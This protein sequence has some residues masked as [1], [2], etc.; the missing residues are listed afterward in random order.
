VLAYLVFLILQPFLVPLAWAIVV[1]VV[2]YEAYEKLARRIGSRPAALVG[3]VAIAVILVAPTMLLMSGFVRQG[4][5]AVKAT[6]VG[7]A[8]GHFDWVNRV[9]EQ[10]QERI[11]GA[12]PQDLATTVNHYGEVV[13]AFVAARLGS[14]LKN[15][16]EF[17]FHLGVMLL[18]VFYLFIDGK[19]IVERLEEVLPFEGAHRERMI[20]EARELIF[21]SVTSSLAAAA[22]H[23]ILGGIAFALTGIKAPIFW[24]VMM[25]FFSFVPVVGS[26]TIWGPAAVSLMVSGHL[27]KGIAL[28]VICAVIVGMVDNVM[29]PWLIRG[30]A[31]MGGLVIFISVLGGITVFGLLGIV[32]GPI[33]VAM[34]ASL[35][36]V[37]APGTPAG[38]MASTDANGP[39]GNARAKASGKKKASVLE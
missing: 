31:E 22:A 16:A 2:S 27:G 19:R 34:A 5:E 8:E 38:E 36:D 13:A 25:A 24:G 20:G 18:A 17:L 37:Y 6:Q 11:P 30:R 21:A 26:A 3:T 12:G 7:I 23:G 10:I 15:T 39:A 29:R 9:W 28:A 32:L 1:V 4:V 33:I 35:L 14:I